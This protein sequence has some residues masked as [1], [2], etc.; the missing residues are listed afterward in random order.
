MEIESLF[1][2]RRASGFWYFEFHQTLLGVRLQRRIKERQ[3]IQRALAIS[4][5][6]KSW[7]H[8]MAQIKKP[9]HQP[10]FT[11]WRFERGTA[12][13]GAFGASMESVGRQRSTKSDDATG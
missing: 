2:G 3:S 9:H 11:M 8:T 10:N 13:L 5:R 1:I 4:F 6:R 7:G 12:L